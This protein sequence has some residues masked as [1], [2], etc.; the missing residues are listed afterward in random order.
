MKRK[1]LSLSICFVLLFGVLAPPVSAATSGATE[2]VSSEIVYYPDGTYLITEITQTAPVTFSR[3]STQHTS[4]SKTTQLYNSSGEKLLSLTVH[5]SFTYNGKTS[6]AISARYSYSIVHSA[7]SFDSG[8]ATCSGR[9]AQATATFRSTLAL[10][11]TAT[12]SLS[13]DIDGVLT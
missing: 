6:E 11:K 2:T 10:P 4:G 5:G 7:W 1:L 13:C 8:S 3:S 9:T 12:V